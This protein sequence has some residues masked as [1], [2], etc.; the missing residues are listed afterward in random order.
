VCTSSTR[1]RRRPHRVPSSRLPVSL[2]GVRNAGTLLSPSF[3]GS[4]VQSTPKMTV[5]DVRQM[6]MLRSLGCCRP[7]W[8]GGYV[9]RCRNCR[10]WR[11]DPRQ[12]KRHRDTHFEHRFSFV[13]PNEFT[14][15]SR[16][17]SFR[18]RDAVSVH[19]KRSLPCGEVLQANQGVIWS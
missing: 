18:R 16:G 17:G 10:Y 1:I 15:P 5:Q 4:P 13:C 2:G 6:S 11:T 8:R 12:V 3:G 14:C 19:R 9:L 7:P